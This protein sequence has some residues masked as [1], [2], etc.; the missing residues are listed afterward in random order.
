M[1]GWPSF[2]DRLLAACSDRH[3]RLALCKIKRQ[4]CL[5]YTEETRERCH[6]QEARP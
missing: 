4:I 3:E 5:A 1:T 6:Q 2:W